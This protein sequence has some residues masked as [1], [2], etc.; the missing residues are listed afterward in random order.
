MLFDLSLTSSAPQ[1]ISSQFL[2]PTLTLK[3]FDLRLFLLTADY[4]A[5]VSTIRNMKFSALHISWIYP[6][7]F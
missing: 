5:A 3:T 6:P 4:G 1:K 7:P 2:G